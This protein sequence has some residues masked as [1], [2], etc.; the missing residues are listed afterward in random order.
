MKEVA[1]DVQL[2]P[3]LIPVGNV[4]LENGTNTTN[5]ARLDIAARGIWSSHERTLFDV[6]I[7]HPFALSNRNKTI[8]ALLAG[9]EAEKMRHYNDRVV[10]VE[11]SSFVPLVYSTN[12]I[13]S[14]QCERLHRQLAWLIAG[15]L[16][17]TYSKI[18]NHI[19][20]RVRFALLKS[21][22]VSIR[23]YRGRNKK[24]YE[25]LPLSDV[26]FGLALDGVGEYD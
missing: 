21:V 11:K 24:G 19:R 9:N 5:Q 22:L 25:A 23:G 1:D 10:Q 18:M 3:H 7:T 8:E 4:Q 20:T 12:G 14:K 6:R 17:E 13:M 16:G 2:E 15:K 26:D